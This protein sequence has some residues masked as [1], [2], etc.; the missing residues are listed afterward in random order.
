M[1]I[2]SSDDGGRSFATVCYDNLIWL[3]GTMSPSLPVAAFTNGVSAY[4]MLAGASTAE[5]FSRMTCA[6]TNGVSNGAFR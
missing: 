3:Y 4:T 5:T 6:G 1:A 2:G